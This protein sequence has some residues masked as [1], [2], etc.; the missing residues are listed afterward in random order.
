MAKFSVRTWNSC[1]WRYLWKY[2][3]PFTVLSDSRRVIIFPLFREKSPAIV[4]ATHPWLSCTTH[5]QSRRRSR[6]CQQRT[7]HPAAGILGRLPY[8]NFS[9]WKAAD[10]SGDDW[11]E[12][13]SFV[14]C[15]SGFG[16]S[17]SPTVNYR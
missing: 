8:T 2:S 7:S 15:V 13:F 6:L 5:L 11:V 10:I 16:M 1:P 17:A 4:T 12:H 9:D 14:N 3:K